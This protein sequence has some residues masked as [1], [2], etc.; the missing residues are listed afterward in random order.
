MNDEIKEILYLE[1][2][3]DKYKSDEKS[4]INGNRLTTPAMLDYLEART[5]LDYITNLQ[6]ENEKLKEILEN[7]TTMTVCDDNKQIKNTAQ[8]KL[9]I[10]KSRNDKAV[11][12][13][14]SVSLY[15]LR[16]GKTLI[17]A[18]INDVLDILEG[19]DTNE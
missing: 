3:V 17:S 19:V 12:K 6:Q 14:K 18:L 7:L 10:Y 16:S 9:D 15:G 5:L 8:Y 1:K 13:L 11:E 2:Y 4:I